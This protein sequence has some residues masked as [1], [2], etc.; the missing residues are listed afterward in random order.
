MSAREEIRVGDRVAVGQDYATRLGTVANV[1]KF[2][3]QVTCDDG[4]NVWYALAGVRLFYRT[5]W[6]YRLRQWWRR[7]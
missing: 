6:L 3:V 5:G 4:V 2:N 1:N 7:L